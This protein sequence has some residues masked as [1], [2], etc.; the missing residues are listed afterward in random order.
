M[1]L[2]KWA[3]LFISNANHNK[4]KCAGFVLFVSI[5]SMLACTSW[6]I[7]LSFNAAFI[8]IFYAAFCAEEKASSLKASHLCGSWDKHVLVMFAWVGYRSTQSIAV[9]VFILVMTWIINQLGTQ[10]FLSQN[11]TALYTTHHLYDAPVQKLHK[12]YINHLNM[13][14]PVFQLYSTIE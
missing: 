7:G 14:H 6:V 13:L 9:P 5:P 2:C 8:F 10:I 3:T 4:W 11:W 1:Q 12:K